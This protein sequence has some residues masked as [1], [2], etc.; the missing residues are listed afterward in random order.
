MALLRI[1]LCATALLIPML[2]R[3]D[4]S[5]PNIIFILVDDK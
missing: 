2:L 3:G 5:R 4:E 1:A